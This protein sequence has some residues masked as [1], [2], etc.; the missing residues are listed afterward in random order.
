MAIQLV[1]STIDFEYI[2]SL[3]ATVLAS[4]DHQLQSRI[5]SRIRDEPRI[6]LIPQSPWLVLSFTLLN[7]LGVSD[8]CQ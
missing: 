8:P 6:S 7:L 3:L 4:H 1:D 5:I 2:E